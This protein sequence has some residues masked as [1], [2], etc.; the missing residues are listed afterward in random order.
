MKRKDFKESLY[1]ALDN[2]V[3]GMSYDEKMTLVHSLLVDYEKDN[4]EKRDISNKGCKW[5]DE[6]LKIILSDAP[7]KENCI[8]YAR[9]FKRGYGSIEQIYRWSVTTTK[10][11]SE[12]R[13][14]DSFIIQVKRIAK[15][16]EIRG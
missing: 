16:L 14:N 4:E 2:E 10:E 5:T 7:T 15:E 3:D 12:E 6:E 9:L 8:K 11:M 1:D 13:K